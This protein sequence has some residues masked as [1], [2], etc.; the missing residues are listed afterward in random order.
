MQNIWLVIENFT[1]SILED[2]LPDPLG[3]SCVQLEL[4]KYKLESQADPAQA[5]PV[6]AQAQN[7]MEVQDEV[8]AKLWKVKW[9]ARAIQAKARWLKHMPSR[10]RQL[11]L[12][13]KMN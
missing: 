10:H 12:R 6:Q 7:Q 4:E 13:P 1:E 11:R 9:K 2:L 8:Q 5:Q 3:M